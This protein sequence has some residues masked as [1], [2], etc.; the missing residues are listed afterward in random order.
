MQLRAEEQPELCR[1]EGEN[2]EDLLTHR[3][4]GGAASSLVSPRGRG[5]GHRGI[6]G[7]FTPGFT[8]LPRDKKTQHPQMLQVREGPC[9]SRVGR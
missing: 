3:R 9:V 5:W 2:P 4:G 8:P 7:D 6:M 1:G